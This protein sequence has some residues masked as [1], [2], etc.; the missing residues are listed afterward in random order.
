MKEDDGANVSLRSMYEYIY[1]R[2][3]DSFNA[4][5][6]AIKARH[7]KQRLENPREYEL[8]DKLQNG[9]DL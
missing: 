2:E 8:L 7:D 3:M 9:E 6:R 5:Q 4:M 1:A